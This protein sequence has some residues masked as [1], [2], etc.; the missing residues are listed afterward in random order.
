MQTTTQA[1]FEKQIRYDHGDFR[2]ELDGQLIGYYPSYLRA[3]EALDD[4]AYERLIHGDCATAEELDGGQPNALLISS[5]TQAAIALGL[6]TSA[7]DEPADDGEAVNWNSIVADDP[8]PPEPNPLGDEEGDSTPPDRPRAECC[9]CGALATWKCGFDTAPTIEYF[10][11]ACYEPTGYMGD[12]ISPDRPRAVSLQSIAID[13]RIKRCANCDGAHFTW[14]C[15]EIASALFA[16]DVAP[17]HDIALGRE[18]CRM[19]WKNFRAFVALLLSVPSAHLII[20]AASYQAF[21]REYRPDSDMTITQVLTA[22]ANDMRRDG[23]RGPALE[24]A[25]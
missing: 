8:P 9:A 4:V 15:P 7:D 12:P 18:L 5:L 17:W 2:A 23:D 6:D 25:A 24:R 10:C 21:I 1:T 22:W 13:A 3:E 19:K 11:E 16:P 14:A 20:Y